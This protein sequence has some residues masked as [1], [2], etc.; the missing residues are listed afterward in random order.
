M[1][2]RESIADKPVGEIVRLHVVM[3]HAGEHVAHTPKQADNRC[4][5]HVLA[6]RL[7]GK[8]I[9]AKLLRQK[10]NDHFKRHLPKGPSM[11]GV[12]PFGT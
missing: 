6:Q 4:P 8:C 2:Q 12:V 11:E 9:T 3:L 7:L 10:A 1:H 5:S